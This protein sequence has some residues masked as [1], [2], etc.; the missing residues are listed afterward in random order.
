[1]N[2]RN[3]FIRVYGKVY[4]MNLTIEEAKKWYRYLQKFEPRVSRLSKII[5][6]YD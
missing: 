1:M 4:A 3:Y 6:K 2:E 5:N